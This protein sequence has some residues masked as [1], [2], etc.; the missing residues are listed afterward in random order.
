[1][2]R[3]LTRQNHGI[4]S[5]IKTPRND[6]LLSLQINSPDVESIFLEGFNANKEKFFEFIQQSYQHM[7]HLENFDRSLKQAKLQE[8]GELDDLSLDDLIDELKNYDNA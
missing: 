7:K 1:M 3:I 4:I 8:N 6:T 5:S 2:T